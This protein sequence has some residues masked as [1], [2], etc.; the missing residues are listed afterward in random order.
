MQKPKSYEIENNKILK[1]AGHFLISHPQISLKRYTYRHLRKHRAGNSLIG[2]WANRSFFAQK[3][4]NERYA[5][6]NERFTHSLIF[7]ERPEQFAHDCSFPLSDVSESLMVAHFWWATWVVLP[8][9]QVVVFPPVQVVV[10][11]PVQVV[12]LPPVHVVV[13]PPVQVVVHEDLPVA[14]HGIFHPLNPRHVLQNLQKI[15]HL[16]FKCVKCHWFGT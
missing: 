1:N 8:P 16:C 13:L 2:F 6:K 12:V 11:P 14:V 10:L 5:Q 9:V 4:T 7:G 15:I 3:W